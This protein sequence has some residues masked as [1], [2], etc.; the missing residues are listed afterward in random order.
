MIVISNSAIVTISTIIAF[1]LTVIAILTAENLG[2]HRIWGCLVQGV[3][4]RVQARIRVSGR[5]SH[6]LLA[7]TLLFP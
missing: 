2:L 5:V 6:H 7:A 4:S 1:L 3:T